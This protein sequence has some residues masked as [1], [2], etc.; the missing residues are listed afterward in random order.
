MRCASALTTHV[1]EPASD[2]R[3]RGN[4]APSARAP[5]CAPAA[6]GGYDLPRSRSALHSLSGRRC[7]AARRRSTIAQ[8]LS[9]CRRCE[10]RFHALRTTQSTGRVARPP[11]AAGGA[12]ASPAHRARARAGATAA[13]PLWRRGPRWRPTLD[14]IEQGLRAIML[15]ATAGLVSAVLCF[16]VD[17]RLLRPALSL[18]GGERRCAQRPVHARAPRQR[19][20][21]RSRMTAAPRSR[22]WWRSRWTPTGRVVDYHIVSDEP[23]AESPSCARNWTTPSSSPISSPRS[24]SASPLP[25]AWCSPSPGSTSAPELRARGLPS[26]SQLRKLRAE[27]LD[28]SAPSGGSSARLS[29]DSFRLVPAAAR[30]RPARRRAIDHPASQEQEARRPRWTFPPRRSASRSEM[31]STDQKLTVDASETLFSILAAMN[32]CG[33]DQDLAN[34]DPLRKTIRAEVAA[35]VAASAAA[36]A[37]QRAAM[38]LLQGPRSRRSFAYPFAIHLAGADHQPAAEVRDHHARI[39]PA[40]RR[41]PGPGH[42]APAAALLRCRRAARDLDEAPAR[43]CRLTSIACTSRCTTCSRAPTSISRL[44]SPASPTAVSPFSSIPRPLPDR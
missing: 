38:Q 33:Y 17:D 22:S 30:L 25:A 31:G 27:P 14:R 15:P 9:D 19:S 13:R 39:R 2:L 18:G 5:N 6:G 43:I 12:R 37:A 3:R 1:R 32:S 4:E 10:A 24:S 11:T 28:F 40:P 20:V 44:P 34:S 8:H 36:A 7:F 21:H 35:N 26:L 16:A 41:R 23:A 42:A 29:F